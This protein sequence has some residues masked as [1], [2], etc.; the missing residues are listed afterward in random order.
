VNCLISDAPAWRA[1]DTLFDGVSEGAEVL[2]LTSS[3]TASDLA[4]TVLNHPAVRGCQVTVISDRS[5]I[6]DPAVDLLDPSIY[7][8]SWIDCQARDGRQLSFDGNVIVIHSDG[9]VRAAVGSAPLLE[10][11]WATDRDVWGPLHSRC[12]ISPMALHDLGDLLQVLSG[13]VQLRDPNAPEFLLD[14]A[15]RFALYTAAAEITNTDGVNTHARVLTNLFD[16]IVEQL[17]GNVPLPVVD[18][19][20]YAPNHGPGLGGIDVLTQALKPTGSI[21]VYTNQRPASKT[22]ERAGVD[23]L[24]RGVQV[25][26]A[27]RKRSDAPHATV[28]QWHDGEH[29]W[30]LTGRRGSIRPR[31]LRTSRMTAPACRSR[32][33]AKWTRHCCPGQK[34]RT[35]HTHPCST[36]P[37]PGSHPMTDRQD[38]NGE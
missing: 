6:V 29:T 21:T 30:T 36:N 20:I 23:G 35:T 31:S 22:I 4:G 16:P 18:L 32:C 14:P 15:G 1:I 7:H 10:G 17:P 5:R 37:H 24:V 8:Q 9:D 2:I 11:R 38:H 28:V 3:L 12:E 25:D 13:S 33:S 19:A 26:G 34:A 27:I